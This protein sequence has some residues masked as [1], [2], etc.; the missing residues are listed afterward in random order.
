MFSEDWNSQQLE[1]TPQKK[2]IAK[3][4]SGKMGNAARW[5]NDL[6]LRLTDEYEAGPALGHFFEW[7]P[8]PALVTLLALLPVNYC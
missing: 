6:I 2:R 8:Q 4:S 3:R 1:E 7:S 5:T